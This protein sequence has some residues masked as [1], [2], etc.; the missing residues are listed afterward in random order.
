LVVFVTMWDN[1]YVHAELRQKGH[2]DMSSIGK[3]ESGL[4]MIM[5][6][7]ALLHQALS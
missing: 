4:R 7:V 6:N 1:N 2:Q 3:M 5:D